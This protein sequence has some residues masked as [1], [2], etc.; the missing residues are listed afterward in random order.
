MKKKVMMK[1]TILGTTFTGHPMRTTCGNTLRMIYYAAYICEKANVP[2]NLFE[3]VLG[4]FFSN[5]AGDD[6]LAFG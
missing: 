1:G 5:H 6:V 2:Y 4:N 3:Y